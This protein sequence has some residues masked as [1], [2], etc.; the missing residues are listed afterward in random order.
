MIT[1]AQAVAQ[2]LRE[3]GND[4]DFHDNAL[5]FKAA[6]TID[7]LCAEVERLT[8]GYSEPVRFKELMNQL[9]KG[10]FCGDVPD[11]LDL[12]LDVQ[13]EVTSALAV[14]QQQNEAVRRANLDCVD[15]FNALMG[16]RNELLAALHEATRCLAWHEEKHGVGMDRQAV[17]NAREAIAKATL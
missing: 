8:E 1:Q 11:D 3:V 16:E 5:V 12:A 2:R 4:Y 14:M 15:H 9:I 13:R 6:S 10:D 17:A 7:T